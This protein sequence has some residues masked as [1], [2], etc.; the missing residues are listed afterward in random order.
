M[1]K[2]IWILMDIVMQV[3]DTIRHV[4]L[5]MSIR[6]KLILELI[7]IHTQMARL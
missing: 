5:H 4:Y 1:H 7:I 3:L 6:V 2:K